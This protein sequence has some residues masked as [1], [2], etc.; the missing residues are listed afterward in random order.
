[1]TDSTIQ[2]KKHDFEKDQQQ[3]AS[4]ILYT[5]DP[6][7]LERMRQKRDWLEQWYREQLKKLS[8]W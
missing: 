2:P 1:M 8:E 7:L 4:P 5:P 6:E 3:F